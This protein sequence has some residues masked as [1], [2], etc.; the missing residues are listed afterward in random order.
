M[1]IKV[2]VHDGAEPEVTQLDLEQFLDANRDGI[3]PE[4]AAE[5]RSCLKAGIAY[6]GGGGAGAAFTVETAHD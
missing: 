1:K 6:H 4:E 5:I 2:Y 3:G